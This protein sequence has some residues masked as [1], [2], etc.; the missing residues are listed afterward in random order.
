[1]IPF[2]SYD[3]CHYSLLLFTTEVNSAFGACWLASSEMISQVL[4]ISVSVNSGGYLPRSFAAKQISTTIHLP[5]SEF[6]SINVI[7]IILDTTANASWPH[8]SDQ[9]ESFGH[10]IL[11]NVVSIS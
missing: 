4:F 7:P 6:L 5:L 1:M 10:C 11:L 2:L 3:T 8:G 9:L